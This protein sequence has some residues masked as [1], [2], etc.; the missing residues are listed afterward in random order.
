MFISHYRYKP[1]RASVSN[2]L[3][4]S[5]PCLKGQ[6]QEIFEPQFFLPIDPSLV[7]DDNTY[8]NSFEFTG[9]LDFAN[10]VDS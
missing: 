10:I 2:G 1:I 9:S 4:F 3:I 7:R 8:E 6:S 5:V